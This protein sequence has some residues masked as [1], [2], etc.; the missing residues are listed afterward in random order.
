[1]KRFPGRVEADLGNGGVIGQR[2]LGVPF[3]R[4]VGG[5]SE[6]LLGGAPVDP[7]GRAVGAVH[8]AGERAVEGL[9]LVR[10]GDR[11]VRRVLDLVVVLVDQV[12]QEGTVR[13]E[14]VRAWRD[15]PVLVLPRDTG[16]VDGRVVLAVEA[17]G[18]PDRV[19]DHEPGAAVRAVIADVDEREKPRVGLVDA[20]QSAVDVRADAGDGTIDALVV[21]VDGRVG[22]S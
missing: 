19:P 22:L 12:G 20:E 7:S 1:M 14:A 10:L 11:L 9:D 8:V 2:E 15:V 17:D 21:A 16:R 13:A 4:A 5:D 18:F 6:G 3:E